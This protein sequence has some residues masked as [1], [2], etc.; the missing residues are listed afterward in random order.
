MAIETEDLR[1]DTPLTEEE[2]QILEK[3]QGN[4]YTAEYFFIQL[5]KRKMYTDYLLKCAQP[6]QD[7]SNTDNS[8]EKVAL[9]LRSALDYMSLA[10]IDMKYF[11]F[12]KATDSFQFD[13]MNQIINLLTDK[14]KAYLFPNDTEKESL[15]DLAK[16][17]PALLY[18]RRTETYD[19]LLTI[20]SEDFR[21]NKQDI[22]TTGRK[23]ELKIT[24]NGNDFILTNIENGVIGS[25]FLGTCTKKLFY[26]ILHLI[27]ITDA[28]APVIKL[29]VAEYAKL[30]GYD[31]S[32]DIKMKNFRKQIKN[33]LDAL[34]NIRIDT[35]Q[36]KTWVVGGYERLKN[37][38]YEISIPQTTLNKLSKKSRPATASI[39]T[40]LYL[41]DNKSQSS[42][43]IGIKL[44]THYYNKGNV[45]AG[46]NTI[47][48]VESLL[49]FAPAIKSTTDYEEQ[50]RGHF[51]EEIKNPLEKALNDNVDVGFLQSWNYKRAGKAGE[52]VNQETVNK[53]SFSEYKTLNIEFCPKIINT[54]A[55]S[56][57]E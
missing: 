57:P 44:N 47:I 36:G 33:D 6:K 23:G 18:T 28:Q 54:T 3:L 51:K 26:Y 31:I 11:D 43:S 21:R 30:I 24:K 2:N 13:N 17:F 32:T 27:T 53:M 56:A 39:P 29:N 1:Q 12:S 40:C 10:L 25:R 48:S 8:L 52:K 22:V 35:P 42:F 38:Y 46:N 7:E 9:N 37:G 16:G 45:K 34:M 55:E 20:C 19:R 15:F 49:T 14:F 4:E 41:I 50:K 5:K